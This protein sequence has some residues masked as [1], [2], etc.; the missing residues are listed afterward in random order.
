VSDDTTCGSQEASYYLMKTEMQRGLNADAKGARDKCL[1]LSPKSCI[2]AQC[3]AE[4]ASL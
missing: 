3:R 1:A 2:A 4:G